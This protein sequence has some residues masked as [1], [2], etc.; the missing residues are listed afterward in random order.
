M[1]D[2]HQT[3]LEYE[4]AVSKRTTNSGK[5]LKKFHQKCFEKYLNAPEGNFF[6]IKKK[7]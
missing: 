1:S 2:Y 3:F 5:N 4:I 7:V 6:V